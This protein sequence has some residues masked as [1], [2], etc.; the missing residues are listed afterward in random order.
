MARVRLPAYS[1]NIHDSFHPIALKAIQN[2]NT[3]RKR[4]MRKKGN[5][6]YRNYADAD[7]EQKSR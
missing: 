4:Q 1:M 2:S 6:I 7:A 3:N 5:T